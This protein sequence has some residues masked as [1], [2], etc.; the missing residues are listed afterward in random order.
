MRVRWQ[1][2]S[3][4]HIG[5]STHWLWQD[6]QELVYVYTKSP[7]VIDWELF[8]GINFPV[9]LAY[10]LRGLSVLHHQNKPSICTG[11]MCYANITTIITTPSPWVTCIHPS[12]N[13]EN[14]VWDGCTEQQVSRLAR[15]W[16][17]LGW[18][19]LSMIWLL[20]SCIDSTLWKWSAMG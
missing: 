6:H 12:E 18:Y 13:K 8:L 11:I 1:K 4:I 16:W 3:H 14:T 19:N 20:W 5:F 7:S 2:W 15:E 10:T 9:A 17:M